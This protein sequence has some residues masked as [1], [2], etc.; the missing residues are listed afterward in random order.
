[1]GTLKV[2]VEKLVF[3][4]YSNSF[5]CFWIISDQLHRKFCSINQASRF[6]TLFPPWLYQEHC[7]FSKC[8]KEDNVCLPNWILPQ[9]LLI[10]LPK[11]KLN[12]KEVLKTEWIGVGWV[13]LNLGCCGPLPRQLAC[14]R[15]KKIWS[16]GPDPDIRKGNSSI[17]YQT[18][19]KTV[20]SWELVLRAQNK[21][22]MNHLLL[23]S[24]DSTEW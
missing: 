5:Q 13:V 10:H 3:I 7:K 20:L 18:P 17:L 11:Q 4:K 19:P 22:E 9:L 21:H 6:S 2:N 8:S 23:W 1:M 12:S 15:S 14:L 24:Y 16:R